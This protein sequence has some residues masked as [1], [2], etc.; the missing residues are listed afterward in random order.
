VEFIESKDLTPEV[1]KRLKEVKSLNEVQKKLK[2]ENNDLEVRQDY[3]KSDVNGLSTK[4]E[5]LKTDNADLEGRIT[6]ESEQLK[7]L[8]EQRETKKRQYD[9]FEALLAMFSGETPYQDAT[10]E[11]LASAVQQL[12]KGWYAGYPVGALRGVFVISVCGGFL[13]SLHCTRCGARF[14]VDRAHN[15]YIKQKTYYDCPV[16]GSFATTKPN[17]DFLKAMSSEEEF[18]RSKA[19]QQKLESLKPL[20]V[21]LDIPCC[22]CHKPMSNIWTRE[23][24][25]KAFNGLGHDPCLR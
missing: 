22:V 14:I 5:V 21:F 13:H 4:K 3:L 6:R 23:Q 20:E 8:K 7:A 25:L 17:D 18:N 12:A 11:K 16:C 19:L 15:S 1:R 9:L 10:P 24:V 2:T